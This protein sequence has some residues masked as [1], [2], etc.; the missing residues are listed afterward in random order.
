MF[1][2]IIHSPFRTMYQLTIRRS[3]KISENEKIIQKYIRTPG[4]SQDSNFTFSIFIWHVL[5]IKKGIYSYLIGHK[6][7]NSGKLSL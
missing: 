1:L 4:Y 6:R 5:V 2:N 3:P 7:H